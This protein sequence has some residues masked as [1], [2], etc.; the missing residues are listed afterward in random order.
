[1]GGQGLGI[2]LHWRR[3]FDHELCDSKD[4]CWP[5][6]QTEMWEL[7][8]LVWGKRGANAWLLP[9]RQLLVFKFCVEMSVI[10]K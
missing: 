10:R 7:L 2:S 8:V 6:P 1:M 4:K 5:F 3:H 9:Y